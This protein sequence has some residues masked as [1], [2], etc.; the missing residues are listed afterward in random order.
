MR[1]SRF[2]PTAFAILIV[3]STTSAIAEGQV[4]GRQRDSS[5]TKPYSSR[6][7]RPERPERLSLFGVSIGQSLADIE[8][9][10]PDKWKRGYSAEH[11][12]HLYR[13]PD[14]GKGEPGIIVSAGDSMPNDGLVRRVTVFAFNP[15]KSYFPPDVIASTLEMTWGTAIRFEGLPYDRLWVDLQDAVQARLRYV[16]TTTPSQLVITLSGYRPPSP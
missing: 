3:A 4:M 7:Y 11:G 12:I 16:T 6:P 15:S 10:F 1:T 14:G 13:M 9:A 8:N 5:H 2:F